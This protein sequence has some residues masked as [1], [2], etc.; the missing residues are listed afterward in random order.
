MDVVRSVGIIQLYFGTFIIIAS[1][2]LLINL[3]S[4]F[5]HQYLTNDYYGNYSPDSFEGKMLNHADTEI[6]LNSYLMNLN[7]KLTMLVGCI[8]ALIL[9]IQMTLT[10]IVNS[11]LGNQEH[12]MIKKQLLTHFFKSIGLS[13]LGMLTIHLIILIIQR[14]F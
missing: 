13:I 8:L 14:I 5:D 2:F 10:G 4:S 1:C 12:V 7:Y 9:G 11:R 3:A 6:T